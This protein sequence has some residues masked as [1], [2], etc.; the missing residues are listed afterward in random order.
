MFTV[1]IDLHLTFS[2]PM[3]D[4]SPGIVLTRSIALPFPPHDGLRVFSA[5]IDMCPE[6]EGL[7]L[8][9]IV[10]DIDRGVFYAST[11]ADS[12]LVPL[13]DI[14]SEIAEWLDKGWRFGSHRD[15]YRQDEIADD[16]PGDEGDETG[17]IFAPLDDVIDEVLEYEKP[18]RKRSI[19]FNRAFKA[20]ARQ[21]AEGFVDLPEAYAMH[22]TGVY[23]HERRGSHK[24]R[25][26]MEGA[27]A[28]YFAAKDEFAKL[29]QGEQYAFREKMLRTRPSLER[30][31]HLRRA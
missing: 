27:E 31:S 10:W 22:K 18:R 13:C 6:P 23:Y 19:E 11:S 12:M 16:E 4:D 24:N 2:P 26:E 7:T 20:M 30:L 8:R 21:L 29:S 17:D 14:P 28:R 9:D 25:R 5:E 15:H 1:E 3:Q